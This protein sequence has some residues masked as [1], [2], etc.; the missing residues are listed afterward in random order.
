M[1]WGSQGQ[2][3]WAHYSPHPQTSISWVWCFVWSI[4]AWVVEW[5]LGWFVSCSGLGFCLVAHPPSFFFF[6][7]PFSLHKN[8]C[9]ASLSGKSKSQ[10]WVLITFSHMRMEELIFRERLLVHIQRRQI[11]RAETASVS[12][13]TFIKDNGCYQVI[14]EQV[15][16]CRL[17]LSGCKWKQKVHPCHFCTS[18]F[19][20]FPKNH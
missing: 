18:S 3:L 11:S 14:P 8:S 19:L 20:L 17:F 12:I 15:A 1:V 4:L 5:L 10:E 6:F 7:S 13:F 16:H 9:T 2:L